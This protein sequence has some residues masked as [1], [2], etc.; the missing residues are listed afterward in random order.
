MANK[1]TAICDIN[2]GKTNFVEKDKFQVAYKKL[3]TGRYLVTWERIYN[4]ITRRQQ[5]TNFGIPY[6]IISDILTDAW[7]RKVDR[8]ETKEILKK[9]CLPKD[10]VKELKKQHRNIC[11]ILKRKGIKIMP[12]FRLT[13]TKLSTVQQNEYYINM[14]NFAKDMFNADIPDPDPR[15]AKDYQEFETM[16][17]KPNNL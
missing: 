4:K 5:R 13:S 10:Y 16:N 8:E 17:L 12:K 7:G 3:V 15:L 11:N 1:L 2:E 6:A 14:Q 9:E